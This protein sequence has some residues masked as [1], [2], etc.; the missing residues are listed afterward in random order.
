[1]TEKISIFS[2]IPNSELSNIT[3]GKGVL[4][5]DKELNEA[6]KHILDST[7]NMDNTD[8]I[9]NTDNQGKDSTDKQTKSAGD[10]VTG[11]FAVE[12]IDMVL[13]SLIS[14]IISYIGYSLPKKSLQLTK[15]EKLSLESPIKSVLDSINLDFSNP[16]INLSVVLCLVYGSKIIDNIQDIKKP[17]DK[18]GI[19]S[20]I[21]EKIG[22]LNEQVGELNNKE[23]FESAYNSLVDE[24][25]KKRNRGIGDAKEYLSK[26]FSEKLKSLLDKFDIKDGNTIESVLNYKHT[27]KKREKPSNFKL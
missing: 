26:N 27:V 21:N 6:K 7:D 25:V 13:P 17:N 5:A 9:L 22:E 4:A 8:N 24:I 10:F 15:D 2:D 11:K 18:K 14:L 20:S 23:K 19:V 1:M 3:D 16:Y 12:L